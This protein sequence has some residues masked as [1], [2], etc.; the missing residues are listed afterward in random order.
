MTGNI[1]KYLKEIFKLTKVFYKN[2]LRKIDHD[3][4]L[5]KSEEYTKQFLKA[6][7]NYIIKMTKKNWRF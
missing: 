1:K 2:C 4:V 7:K 5:E 6:K 3:K